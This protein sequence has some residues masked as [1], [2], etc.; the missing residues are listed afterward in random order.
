MR[1][2]IEPC[3]DDAVGVRLQRTTDAGAALAWRLVAGGTIGLR[4]LRWWQRGIIGRLRR[5]LERGQPLLQFSDARQCRFQ[6]PDQGQ[7]R[8]DEVI[9]LRVA[10]RAEVDTVRHIEVE[11]SRP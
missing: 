2:S 3:I 4:A 9:L 1:A 10:Q 6:L 7:Q 8:Q 5:S 11:S